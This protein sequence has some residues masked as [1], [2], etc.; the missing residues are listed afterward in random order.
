MLVGNRMSKNPVTVGLKD[1]L[2]TARAKMRKKK[3]Y[4]VLGLHS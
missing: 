4:N 2:A 3:G 1:S